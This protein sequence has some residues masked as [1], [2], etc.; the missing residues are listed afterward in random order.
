MP[1]TKPITQIYAARK[2]PTLEDVEA[3]AHELYA[4]QLAGLSTEAAEQ[5][6]AEFYFFKLQQDVERSYDH[7]GTELACCKPLSELWRV[8]L[9][10]GDDARGRRAGTPRGC[11]QA[12]SVALRRPRAGL[13]RSIGDRLAPA[14]ERRAREGNQPEKEVHHGQD[15][16]R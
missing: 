1:E 8:T 11:G 2:E 14:K 15:Q 10:S 13:S 5:W 6:L 16:R 7:G 3:Q 4:S 12:A 9:Q